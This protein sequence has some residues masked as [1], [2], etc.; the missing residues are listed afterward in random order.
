MVRF[1][2]LAAILFVAD[3][4]LDL[5]PNVELVSMLIMVY[6][7]TYRGRALIPLYV[8]V[9]LNGALYGFSLY[10]LSYLYIWLILWGVTMLL[11]RRMPAAVA[12]P[13]CAGVCALFG[14]SFGALYA[15]G[16]ML[17]AKLNL[18]K[19]VAWWLAGLSFDVI[20]AAGNAAFGLLVWPLYK[21]LSHI[22]RRFS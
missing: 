20:H 13:V 17:V 11:P 8:Y 18:E 22:E 14:L 6:T 3:V 4:V 10:N 16:W 12:V 5:A 1:A 7:L 19:I 21:T 2:L 9:L 15:P